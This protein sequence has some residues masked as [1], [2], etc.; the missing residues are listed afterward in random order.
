[1]GTRLAQWKQG[2]DKPVNDFVVTA[3]TLCLRIHP[4]M[5][6]E[7]LVSAFTASLRPKMAL[8][9][10]RQGGNNATARATSASVGRLRQRRRTTTSNT[11]DAAHADDDDQHVVKKIVTRHRGMLFHIHPAGRRRQLGA[12]RNIEATLVEYL[13]RRRRGVNTD[14]GPHARDR[15]ENSMSTGKG[16]ITACRQ[17]RLGC[18]PCLHYPRKKLPV[19]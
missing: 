6:A 12:R 14:G 15:R 18:L 3:H 4:A 11:V 10:V 5:A 1:M 17:E 9:C 2:R 13:R 7:N 8:S 19:R 16:C